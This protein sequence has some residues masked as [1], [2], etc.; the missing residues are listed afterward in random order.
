MNESLPH[1]Q[2]LLFLDALRDR[3]IAADSLNSL[4]FSMANDLH[5]LLNFRQ[6]LVFAEQGKRFELLCVSGLAK[7]TEDSP[8]LVWLQRASRW[9]GAQLGDGE[10]RWLARKAVDPPADIADG[11]AE[12]WPA[13]LWCVPIHEPDGKRLGLLV[14]LLDEPPSNA[15][16]PTLRGVVRTWGYCWSALLRQ[17]RTLGW[18]PTRRQTVS[19]ALVVAI[20][21]FIPVPQ[22]VLAPAEIVS[23]DARIISSPIDGVIERMA[24][25]PN[26]PVSAGT[27]LF[28]LNETSL[29]SRVEVLTKQ[30][31]VA[32]AELMAASQRAFD[33]PQS[34]NEL[35]VLGGVAEQRRAELAAVT[36]Q[37]QRTQV[38]AP[39][40][41]VA[42]FSDPNDWLG[43]PVVTGERILQLADPAK[44][45]M[46]IQLPVAD[47]IALE[48]GAQVTLYLTA[49]PLAPLHGRILET[50]YQAKASE[51][52]VVAYRLLASIDTDGK[53]EQARLGLHGTAKLYG[54][55]VS[56][57]YYLLRR[58]L[59]TLR[60]WTGL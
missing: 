51:D 28:T 38:F 27:L 52:G 55:K 31:A 26:Q 25:R 37:L 9:I 13:G 42:V 39:E 41:G 23:S 47:A 8:Y 57:A 48:P 5:S 21:L 19:A 14:L 24:V 34:K 40:A 58:P 17:R 56:L 45:A 18:R 7:P 2:L 35:T 3:A 59:A 22:T 29:R 43:K 20:L 50:S 10:P 54:K 11:W 33:N 46:L 49:Y 30:V 6:A 16:A 53:R 44:P 36:A 12:W 60:A 32:D 15:M 4:A 1:P